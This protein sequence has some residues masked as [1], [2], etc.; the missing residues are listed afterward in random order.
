[1]T[2]QF[3]AV[4]I[5]DLERIRVGESDEWW[6]PVRRRLGVR[7]FGINA[8]TADEAGDE[9]IGPHAETSASAGGHEELYVVL[10]GH[11][12]FTVAGQEI[13]APAGTL[14]FVPDLAA[15]RG[16]VARKPATTVL[17][18][19]APPG[20]AFP[21]SPWEYWYA[22][23]PFFV[24]GDYARAVEIAS[25][26]L[27]DWPDHGN[28][29]YQL[30]CYHAQAGNRDEALHHLRRAVAG[31]PRAREWAADDSDLDPI[32]DDPQFPR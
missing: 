29:N 28:L 25:E 32:R 2:Q 22:A 15:T 13:D 9:L 4:H 8:F 21:G 7:A 11:A 19:G 17:V 24:A 31:D 30:A 6:R 3:H 14:V 12:A 27:E 10:T 18:I 23:D 16:A 20:N 26:G 5:D 1:M